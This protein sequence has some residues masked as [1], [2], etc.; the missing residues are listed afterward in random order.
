MRSPSTLTTTNWLP[1]SGSTLS[2][3]EYLGR[4]ASKSLEYL[5]FEPTSE[6]L[7]RSSERLVVLRYIARIVLSVGV[8]DEQEFQA[9]HT[10]VYEMRAG[11]WLAVWSQATAIE[12]N[13]RG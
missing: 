12:E 2:K 8:A 5:V 11:H 7:A 13:A 9:W 10:D 3:D 1:P 4:V 6:I